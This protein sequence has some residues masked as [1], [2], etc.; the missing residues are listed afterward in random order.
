MTDH[1]DQLSPLGGVHQVQPDGSFL[2]LPE[3]LQPVAIDTAPLPDAQPGEVRIPE[4][5]ERAEWDVAPPSLPPQYLYDLAQASLTEQVEAQR[6]LLAQPAANMFKG[7]PHFLRSVD[8]VELCGQC[9]EAFPCESY[10]A[11]LDASLR[12]QLTPASGVPAA[13]VP[14]TMVEAA[15]AAGMDVES[16]MERLRASRGL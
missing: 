16:F 1:F 8:G 7:A 13:L 3:A 2:P 11:L 9:G 15:A 10:R 5:P 6:L 14:P 12:D 4:T